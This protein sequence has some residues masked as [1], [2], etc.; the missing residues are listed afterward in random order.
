MEKCKKNNYMPLFLIGSMVITFI[1]EAI[2]TY[3][4]SSITNNS[5]EYN[6]IAMAADLAG[7][8]WKSTILKSHYYGYT[9]SIIFSLLLRIKVV[10]SN[11][12]LLLHVLLLV[13]I[14][15]NALCT[16]FLF[17]I[18]LIIFKANY[19]KINYAYISLIAITCS[20]LISNQVLA[21]TVTNENMFVLCYYV[22][23]Y[24]ILSGIGK[25]NRKTKILN[26]IILSLINVIAYATNG[27]GIILI[28]ITFLMFVI[29]KI[30]N[31]K[32]F[33]NFGIFILSFVLFFSVS[34]FTKKYFVD[35]YFTLP[36]DTSASLKNS[37]IS[38]IINRAISLLNF[39]GIKLYF[40]LIVGWGTYFIVSTYGWGLVAIMS[41]C[42]KIMRRIKKHDDV[43][44][45]EFLLSAIILL[46]LIGISILGI[47]FYHDSFYAMSYDSSDPLANGRVDKLIYGRYIS[48]IKSIILATEFIDM[49]LSKNNIKYYF[50][51]LIGI[52]FFEIMFYH[53]IIPLMIMKR[54]AAVDIPE[55]A[56][57]FSA[58]DA[59]YKFGSINSVS[60]FKLIF[61]LI[62]C[63]YV[64]MLFLLKHQKKLFIILLILFLNISM[65]IGFTTKLV[66][67]RTAYYKSQIDA[68]YIEYINSEYGDNNL[69]IANS[70]TYLYQFFL[71]T[72]KVITLNTLNEENTTKYNNIIL[73]NVTMPEYESCN[74]TIS[75]LQS[76]KFIFLEEYQ[77]D[78]Y[79]LNNY[80]NGIY[81]YTINK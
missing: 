24:C 57:F 67:P 39:K 10:A 72:N 29:V 12:N 3:K 45:A 1:V 66:I 37:D 44:D 60:P 61:T 80:K 51:S 18:I 62:L 9:A 32:P 68:S 17:L 70:N 42:K 65:G 13:N 53:E 30:Y 59:D 25:D 52:I 77:G 50:F 16:M 11:P 54:Y 74:S 73:I 21:K 31:T 8:D 64:A 6:V 26:S 78:E 75:A 55:F 20:L 19:W 43:A 34:I 33:A 49:T 36:A 56:L 4:I 41:A 46:F 71:P 5:S 76:Y 63:I 15:I 81:E 47:A 48:S 35:T 27:R 58:F 40:K 23:I 69:I 79:L 14:T 22:A 38:G 28:I 7:Y 2:G